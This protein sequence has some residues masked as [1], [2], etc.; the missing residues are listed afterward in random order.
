MRTEYPISYGR[1]HPEP[2]DYTLQ[3]A[4]M[5]LYAEIG[6]IMG[7]QQD[8]LKDGADGKLDDRALERKLCQEITE[9]LQSA[10]RVRSV[11]HMTHICRD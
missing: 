1:V 7:L 3:G 10:Q 9:L 2:K 4:L 8:I 6:D 5:S 11:L